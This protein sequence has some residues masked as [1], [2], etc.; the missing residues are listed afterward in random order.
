MKTGNCRTRIIYEIII[1]KISQ[2]GFTRKK[3]D[4]EKVNKI[5]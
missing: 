3:T 5:K 1:L 2:T 4:E